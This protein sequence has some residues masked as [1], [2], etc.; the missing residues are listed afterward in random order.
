MTQM[1]SCNW[2]HARDEWTKTMSRNRGDL[3]LLLAF[4]ALHQ[5]RSVTRAAARLGLTQP[6]MSHALNRLRHMF[7][8]QLFVRE[9]TG[10][11]PTPR[12]EALAL[13]IRRALAGLEEIFEAESF[14]PA[15]ADREFTIAINNYTAAVLAPKII[16]SCQLAAPSIRLTMRPSG[17]LDTVSLLDRGEIDLAISTPGQ[18]L[19]RIHES[20]LIIDDYVAITRHGHP[21]SGLPVDLK[22]LASLPHLSISSSQDDLSFLDLEFEQQGLR[23]NITLKAPL[24]STGPIIVQSDCIAI[25]ARNLAVSLARAH[26][27]DVREIPPTGAKLNTSMR[28]ARR[29]DDQAAHIW[30]RSMVSNAAAQVSA[31]QS[32]FRCQGIIQP[33]KLA[34]EAVL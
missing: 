11:R 23:R 13:P 18:E 32:I 1:H 17:T 9:P 5:D 22:L 30:L 7:H 28:W 34:A 25:L 10:M 4:E 3:N 24:L 12:A 16:T 14:D 33:E 20:S 6:A 31:A 21:T 2:L 8:D 19:E 29:F 26:P 15:S 27:I